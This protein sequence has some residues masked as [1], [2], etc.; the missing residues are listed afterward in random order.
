MER[1]YKE[2][3]CSITPVE[4]IVGFG[5]IRYQNLKIKKLKKSRVV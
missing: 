3:T 4:P 2:L 1:G 5:Q